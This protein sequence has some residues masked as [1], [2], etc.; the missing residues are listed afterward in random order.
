MRSL[1]DI[2]VLIALLDQFAL[3][4][5]SEIQSQTPQTHRHESDAAISKVVPLN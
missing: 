2:N 1:L 3:E 4:K 5:M